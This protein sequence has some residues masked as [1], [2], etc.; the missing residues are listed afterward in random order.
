M[1]KNV[2]E[3]LESSE[4]RF[5][6]RVAYKDERESYTFFQ[7]GQT[8]RAVGTAVAGLNQK[9]RPVA[10]LMEKSASMIVSFLGIA[11]GGMCYCPVDVQMPAE[12]IRAVLKVLDPAA[13]ITETEFLPLTEELSVS[14]PVFLFHDLKGKQADLGL[15]KEIRSRSETEDPLYVLFTS[16]STGVPKG[17][18]M[19]HK[20][21]INNM[22]WL[23]KEFDFSEQDVMGNQ[24]PL[25]FDVS[26]HDVYCPLAFGCSTVIIPSGYFSFPAKLFP[27]LNENRVSGIFWVPFALCAAADLGAFETEVPRFLRHVFFAGEVMPVKQLNVWRNF[28]PDVTYVN[29]YGSTETHVTMYYKVDREFSDGERLPLGSP[30]AN[31]EVM[32]LDKEGR[33]VKPGTDAIGEL[34]IRG[35]YFALG[36]YGN[37]A[38]TREKF[39]RDPMLPD[40]ETPV[41]R[42]GDMVGFNERGELIYINRTD[43]QVKRLGYR[44]ELGEIEAAAGGIDGIGRCACVYDEKKKTILFFYSGKPLERKSLVAA[45]SRRLPR[46]M[47][48]GRFFCLEKL[49]LNGSGKIDR[50]RLK[51]LYV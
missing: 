34:C 4:K 27:F 38:L 14:C 11:Y 5:P 9:G 25:H 40:S 44:I 17:V 29:M 3:Y 37:E 7:T 28:L 23:K 12:R 16:G 33:P 30:C 43:Y 31:I 39:V 1:V 6:E 41:Y 13:V 46:Y 36:Y 45:L 2:L 8:A 50:K 24:A 18:L 42:T 15:L 49:P 22:E 35:G 10:V 21:I 51:E 48:P 20:V 47:M 32:V 19:S 26:V